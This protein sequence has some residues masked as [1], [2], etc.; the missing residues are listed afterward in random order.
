[1][2]QVSQV[3]KG[4]SGLRGFRLSGF[5]APVGFRRL[6]GL[7]LPQTRCRD[8]NVCRD[9]NT[10]VY[11]MSA[12][13]TN[14]VGADAPTGT[15][16]DSYLLAAAE[17]IV[18]KYPTLNWTGVSVYNFSYGFVKMQVPF[19]FNNAEAKVYRGLLSADHK[20]GYDLDYWSVSS[21]WY[22]DSNN[23]NS[24][25][26]LPFT[27]NALM[28]Q[29]AGMMTDRG[30]SFVLFAPV[31]EVQA[32]YHTKAFNSTTPPKAY[33]PGPKVW[34]YVLAAPTY[35]FIFRYKNPSSAW[36]G[37]PANVP[38]AATT[39]DMSNSTAGCETLGSWAPKVTRVSSGAKGVALNGLRQLAALVV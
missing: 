25:P 18:L 9:A 34:A 2:A 22:Q 26:Q 23:S 29:D 27:V 17:G 7:G 24:N 19:V 30:Y 38:C 15:C 12:D 37:S 31:S 10:D 28:M 5:K 21:S 39:N 6:V 36:A 1:M 20:H 3:G 11:R 33:L 13:L 14:L 35:A 4:C 8:G 16:A 32:L